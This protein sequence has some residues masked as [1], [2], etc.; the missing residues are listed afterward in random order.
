[1]PSADPEPPVAARRPAA[2]T[3][4]G[5]E[6]T[7]DYA[8]LKDPAWQRVMREPETLDHDIR[9]Y[10]EAENACKD[11][12]LAPYAALRQLLYAEMRGR[13]K[14]D[15]STVPAPDGAWSYYVR[16]V[17]GGEHPL[18]CRTRRGDEAAE[19]L[20]L[21]GN[22]EAADHA[23]F[24]LGACAHST[25]HRR[26]AYALDLNGSERYRLFVRDIAS[27]AVIDGPIEDAHG[28]VVWAA[29]GETV[30]YTVIDENHRPYQVRR[31]RVGSAAGADP[32]VY[33]ESDSG[34][35][36]DL[37]KSESGRFVMN[38][39]CTWLRFDQQARFCIGGEAEER[40]ES[41]V[42]G[43][44]A[45]EAKDELIEIGL[46]MLATQP[47]VDASRPSFEVGEDLVDPRQDEVSGG[48]PDDMDIVAIGGDRSVAGPAVGFRD[49]VGIG[50][51]FDEVSEVGG[52]VGGDFGQPQAAWDVSVP[53]FDGADDE[54]LA[55]VAASL[56][57]GGRIVFGPEWKAGLVD[58][59]Q[60]RQRVALGV[61]HA[62]AQLVGEQ[63]SAA[64]RADT[65]LFLELQGRDAV[66]VGRHQV[67]GPE[68]D[69]ERQLAGVQDRPG[70]H[71]GLPA[72]AGALEGVCFSAQ[73]P[74]LFMAARGTDEAVRPAHFDQPGGAGVIV[75]E[76]V[77]EGEEAVGDLFHVVAPSAGTYKE[78]STRSPALTPTSTS[79]GKLSRP[80]PCA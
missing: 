21:D 7:D 80:E 66:G 19:A 58:F 46:Q 43:F 17:E 50:G 73:R 25:D 32:V 34:F 29:D 20:L 59:H 9:A 36:V 12:F 61:D 44:A 48:L 31:H 60:A 22:R 30:F 76:H 8:W 53:E 5:I 37:D 6:R 52:A 39:L 11:A 15:D 65:E 79:G 67:G 13:M 26:L 23:Y 45:V 40:A 57:S 2:S 55:V 62:G 71:R 49:G 16:Y 35:F 68:P 74:S 1:M 3:L 77:L 72:A 70:R 33:E 14:E 69:G 38:R 63:P 18:Y 75:R 24:R 54:H 28:D 64:V 47:V 42:A 4:H 41:S 78:H 27:G 10:L 56:S 51:G